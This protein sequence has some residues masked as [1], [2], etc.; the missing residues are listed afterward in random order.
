MELVLPEAPQRGLRAEERTKA[1][2]VPLV[3]DM[4]G[5][6]RAPP[7]AFIIVLLLSGPYVQQGGSRGIPLIEV[8]DHW[9][10][11]AILWIGRAQVHAI[12]YTPGGRHN[13][14]G[15]WGESPGCFFFH[16]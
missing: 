14:C 15:V 1:V 5:I 10:V 3:K 13:I 2:D 16:L 12:V 4:G 7:A 8:L 11:P 9:A 6:T